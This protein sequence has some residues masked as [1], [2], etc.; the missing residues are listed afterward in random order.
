MSNHEIAE[1]TEKDF[2]KNWVNSSRF[3]FYLQVFVVIAFLLGGCY[4][5]YQ[6]RYPGKPDVQVQGSSKYV[7]EYK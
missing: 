2:T 3:L 7:P 4:R 5:L 6:Q 1:T